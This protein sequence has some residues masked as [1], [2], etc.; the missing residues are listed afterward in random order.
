MAIMII[1]LI[2][3]AT[4]DQNGVA[5]FL[6]F[7]RCPFSK[8]VVGCCCSRYVYYTLFTFSGMLMEVPWKQLYMH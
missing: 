6:F 4:S 5:I 2:I 3:S 1:I 7:T 8:Y